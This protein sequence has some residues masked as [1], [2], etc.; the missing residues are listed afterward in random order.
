MVR[1][2]TLSIQTPGLNI[3]SWRL[4]P[5]AVPAG[6][7][8]S[9]PSF[10]AVSKGACKPQEILLVQQCHQIMLAKTSLDTSGKAGLLF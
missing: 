5:C 3:Q 7:M 9:T 4:P 2:T 6:R 10:S 8:H 1:E